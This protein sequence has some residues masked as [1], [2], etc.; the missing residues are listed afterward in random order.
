MGSG[1]SNLNAGPVW[2]I[3]DGNCTG[4]LK[5]WS[6]LATLLHSEDSSLAI[7]G[8]VVLVFNFYWHSTFTI[9]YNW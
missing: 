4:L 9:L 5:P 6:Y 8:S 3:L 1:P 7:Q 2:H